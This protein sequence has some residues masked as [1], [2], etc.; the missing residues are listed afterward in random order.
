MTR[1]DAYGWLSRQLGIEFKS[2]HIGMFDV[3]MCQKVIE[4]CTNFVPEEPEIP[5]YRIRS[6]FY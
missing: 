1:T 2:C 4:V 3:E 5:W 6:N